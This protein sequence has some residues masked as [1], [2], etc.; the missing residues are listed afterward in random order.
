MNEVSG[1]ESR[2]L[3]FKTIDEVGAEGILEEPQHTREQGVTIGRI[4]CLNF[5]PGTEVADQETQLS[6]FSIEIVPINPVSWPSLMKD[7]AVFRIF[8]VAALRRGVCIQLEKRLGLE[9]STCLSCKVHLFEKFRKCVLQLRLF[10]LIGSEFNLW[11]NILFAEDY[12]L[13]LVEHPTRGLASKYLPLRS[14][15]S[16]RDYLQP[17][18]RSL[19]S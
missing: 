9:Q 16:T 17:V 7:G 6:L 1:L 14:R 13:P 10:S 11:G 18:M 5:G 12:S 3:I 4:D 15:L 19:Y 8:D 2:A